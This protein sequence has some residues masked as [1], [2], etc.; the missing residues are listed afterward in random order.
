[1]FFFSFLDGRPLPQSLFLLFESARSYAFWP[2]SS[3]TGPLVDSHLLLKDYLYFI[4]SARLDINRKFYEEASPKF[5]LS[6]TKTF[7]YIGKSSSAITMQCFGMSVPTIFLCHLQNSN[8][9]GWFQNK[10]AITLSWLVER[11]VC[12]IC[13]RG[14]IHDHASSRETKNC[15]NVSN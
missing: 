3:K 11:K 12:P 13:T 15:W 2:V 10:K 8:C 4:A 1:M 7:D 5:P 9:F 6:I 14:A